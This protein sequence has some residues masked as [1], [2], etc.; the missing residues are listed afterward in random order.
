[1]D[2]RE[3]LLIEQSELQDACFDQLANRRRSKGRDPF[4]ALMRPQILADARTGD[5]APVCD[6][7]HALQGESLAKLANLTG[8]RSGVACVAL[9]DFYGD[10]AALLVRQ[11]PVDDL[12]LVVLA[13]A[14]VAKP[15]QRTMPSL[16]VAR[17]HV[18]QRE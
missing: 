5:H 16:E 2:L 18:V 17:R 11:N 3:I 8:H 1:M 6:E 15:R 9:E 10:R 4:D 14:G 13:V 12:Q 7:N